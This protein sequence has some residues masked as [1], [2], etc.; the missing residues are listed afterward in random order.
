MLC[1]SSRITLESVPWP[2]TTVLHVPQALSSC[3]APCNLE[4]PARHDSYITGNAKPAGDWMDQ[5][6]DKVVIRQ[7]M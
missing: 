1:L 7:R 6:R 5:L 2:V 4:V 3:A